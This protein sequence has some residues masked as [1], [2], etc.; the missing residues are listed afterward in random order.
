ML[1]SSLAILTWS[2]CLK[3]K[4]NMDNTLDLKERYGQKL[5]TQT[6]VNL[7]IIVSRAE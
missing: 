6:T 3:H 5:W 1:L 4:L 7:R 2:L